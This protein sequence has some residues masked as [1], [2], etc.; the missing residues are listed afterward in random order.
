M[1]GASAG[2]QRYHSVPATGRQLI[3]LCSC[4]KVAMHTCQVQVLVS[5]YETGGCVH[6]PT[7]TCQVIKDTQLRCNI[8]AQLRL[9]MLSHTHYAR[10][11]PD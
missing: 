1:L 7:R 2:N 11:H 9:D 8:A 6:F 5:A 3:W 4:N 10:R